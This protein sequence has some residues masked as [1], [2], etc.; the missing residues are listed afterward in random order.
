MPNRVA[1]NFPKIEIKISLVPMSVPYHG[2]LENY[3]DLHSRFHIYIA[4]GPSEGHG[5]IYRSKMKILSS[6]AEKLAKNH[7][8][9]IKIKIGHCL[10]VFGRFLSPG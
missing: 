7:Q 1:Q 2:T 8:K 9:L 6:L 5:A 10:Q 3:E 4:Q